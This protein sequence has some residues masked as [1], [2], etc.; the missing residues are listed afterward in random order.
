M[1]SAALFFAITVASASNP[2]TLVTARG[3]FAGGTFTAEEIE[4]ED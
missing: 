3:H 1:T 2:G 4:I